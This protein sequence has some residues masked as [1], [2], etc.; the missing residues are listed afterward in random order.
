MK[1]T[2]NSNKLKEH[3]LS[4]KHKIEKNIENTN[5]YIIISIYE[6]GGGAKISKD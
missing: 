4:V 1:Y 3:K 5:L 6:E 2:L